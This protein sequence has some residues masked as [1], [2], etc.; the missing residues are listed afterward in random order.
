MWRY[1]QACLGPYV[2]VKI[3]SKCTK[4][5]YTGMDVEALVTATN[6]G[7]LVSDS[8]SKKQ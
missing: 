5:K 2:V 3:I 1:M 8:F 7:V 4:L 6:T